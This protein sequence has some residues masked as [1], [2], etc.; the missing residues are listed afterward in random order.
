MLDL[1]HFRVTTVWVKWKVGQFWKRSTGMM[2]QS[3][4]DDLILVMQKCKNFSFTLPPYSS[5]T[6]TNAF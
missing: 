6:L 2:G 1:A 4:P 3:L 5:P